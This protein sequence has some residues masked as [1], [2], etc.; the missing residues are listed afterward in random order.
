MI[1]LVLFLLGLESYRAKDDYMRFWKSEE[2]QNLA[3]FC[4]YLQNIKNK[5]KNY[6]LI[7]LDFQIS[8]FNSFNFFKLEQLSRFIFLFVKIFTF[9]TFG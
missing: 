3:V 1:V 5:N 4:L 6:N 7:T 2:V 9:L 8:Q